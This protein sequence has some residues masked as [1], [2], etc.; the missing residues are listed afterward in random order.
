MKNNNQLVFGNILHV[1]YLRMYRLLIPSLLLLLTTLAEAQAPYFLPITPNAAG[2]RAACTSP[3][4]AGTVRSVGPVRGRTFNIPANAADTIFLCYNDSTTITHNGNADLSGD[5]EPR[6]RGGVGY[7]IYKCAPTRTGPE[8]INIA[9]DLCAWTPQDPRNGIWLLGAVSRNGTV[10]IRNDSSFIRDPNFGD[11]RPVVVTLAPITLDSIDAAGRRGFFER[12]GACVNVGTGSAFKV[13]YLTGITAQVRSLPNDDDCIRRFVVSGGYPHLNR[14]ASYTIDISLVSNP[15]VKAN[16]LTR[17]DTYRHGREIIFSV[18]QPGVYRV[19]IQDG[20][21]CGH[22][23]QINASACNP[24]D[25]VRLVMPNVESSPGSRICLPITARGYRDIVGTSFSVNWNPAILRYESTNRVNPAFPT[26]GGLGVGFNTLE[27]SQGNLGFIVSADPQPI[28]INDRDTLFE[29]C[30]V[31]TGTN[32]QCSPLRINNNPTEINM[33]GARNKLAISIDTGRVC[34][35]EIPLRARIQVTDSTCSGTATLR[36]TPTGG[37]PDY[38]VETRRVPSGPRNLRTVVAGQSITLPNLS[39]DTI[40][41]VIRDRNGSGTVTFDTTVIVNIPSL[42]ASMTLTPPKCFGARDGSIAVVV[43]SGGTV[44]PNPGSAFRFQWGTNP[45]VPNPTGATQTGVGAGSYSVTVTQVSTGCSVVSSNALS[46]PQRLVRGTTTPTAPTCTGVSNGS[47]SIMA[48]GGTTPYT[49]N[50]AV[51]GLTGGTKTPVTGTV[52]N[53]SVVSN[54]AEGLYH[55]TITDANSCRLIDSVELRSVKVVD[56]VAGTIT[57]TRCF[58]GSDGSVQISVTETPAGATPTYS[59]TWNNAGRGTVNSTNTGSTLSAAP[60]GAYLVTA[61]DAAGCRDTLTVRIG[62]PERLVADTVTFRNPSCLRRNDGQLSVTGI[63]GTGR[64]NYTYRWSP[65]GNQQTSSISGLIPGRYSVTVTDANRCV[66]SLVFNLRLPNPPALQG[67]DSTSV[68]CGSD[69]CLTVRATGASIFRWRT[70]T[71]DSIGNTAQVCNLRGNTYTIRVED[72]QSCFR[73]DTVRLGAKNALTIRDTTFTRPRCAGLNNGSVGVVAIGGTPG[74]TY[75]WSVP[76]QTSATLT[77]AR[78][79]TYTVTVTDQQNCTLTGS[80]ALQDPPRITLAFTGLVGTTCSDTCNGRVRVLANYN[81]TPPTSGRF[82]YSWGGGSRDSLRV[83]ACGGVNVVTVT[84][85]N[86]CFIVDSV[87]I[88]SP[89]PVTADSLRATSVTCFGGR[90]GQVRVQGAGGAGGP[91]T[92]LWSNQ[93]RSTTP[94]VI[95]MIAGQ[96]TVTIRDRNGCRGVFTTRVN[97]PD[98]LSVRIDTAR[99][100][101]VVCFGEK[102]AS[103]AI[104]V[105]GGNPGTRT[106]VWT[107]AQGTQLGSAPVL[108]KIGAGLYTVSITDA[109]GCTGVARGLRLAD[110]SPIR[111]SFRPL[112]PLKC[113][114]DNTT[115]N[116]DTISGGSG[117]PYRYSVDFGVQ[118]NRDFPFTLNGGVH[119]VTYFDRLGCAFTDTITVREPA[120]IVVTFNPAVIR[121]ELGDSIRL[122][123]TITGA[124]VDKFTW[125]PADSSLRRPTVLTPFAFTFENKTYTLT[126]LD[127]NGCA[128][129]GTVRI[130]VDPSR[131]LYIPNV[132]IPGNQTGLNDHFSPKSGRS[133]ETINFFQVFNRWGELMYEQKNFLPNND[134]FGEGWDGTYRGRFVDPGVYTYVAQVKFLDGRLLLYQ[135]DVTVLR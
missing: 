30:F 54:R 39:R 10:R 128:G 131:N 106:Y 80:F 42:G 105:V 33:E 69:G 37:T 122:V 132:F 38:E 65:P 89:P 101:R 111:G 19:T 43:S 45:A 99:S 93:A 31:V 133:V 86:N 48:S 46:Q 27:T 88:A 24:A 124:V 22:T 5:P 79:G 110:P 74:Y 70:I 44:V 21:T 87:S 118:L 3:S 92:Y 25:N 59:F 104:N 71:G 17:A 63:G 55:L 53:P 52:A 68:K 13:A 16:I 12:N 51:S 66:D 117:G 60:A 114:G 94:T 73:I 103:L 75:Q 102:T 90:D 26:S 115:L 135:G 49:F 125:V 77:N 4:S 1:I 81:T 119:Y 18:S 129:K 100:T 9:G 72:N 97:Q 113:N 67:I 107:N 36:I 35:R 130:E 7:A 20:K 57:N 8:L 78:A 15:A 50:W 34:V 47:L 82:T 109:K 95:D 64:P 108:D 2:E 61:R 84:D 32:N 14:N 41:I 98:S 91:F 126:V 29:V 76:N 112:A 6:T 83:N 123:P 120:P 116:V 56:V 40:R 11:G 96:Y 121:I 23:F 62:Q 134:D 127:R 28:T 85:A 58:G